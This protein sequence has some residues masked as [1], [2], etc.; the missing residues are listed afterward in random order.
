[1]RKV[2]FLTRQAMMSA[3]IR[4]YKTAFKLEIDAGT[5]RNKSAPTENTQVLKGI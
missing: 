1:M 2:G 5:T 3:E 4:M